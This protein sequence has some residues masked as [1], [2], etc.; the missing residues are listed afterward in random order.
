MHS[1][2]VVSKKKEGY[3]IFQNIQ[4]KAFEES[5]KFN[6]NELPTNLG[7]NGTHIICSYKKDY[8]SYSVEKNFALSRAP[9]QSKYPFF[10]FTGPNEIVFFMDDVGIFMDSSFM[11]KQKG[12]IT[13]T[14]PKSKDN[15]DN[16]RPI[17]DIALAGNYCLI[18]CEGILQIFTICT[19]FSI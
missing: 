7:Y 18:L 6:L 13:L 16:S 19:D 5:R 1:I 17:L 9:F 12:N 14:F 15:S 10:K 3:I 8:E 11:P 2:A 4:T